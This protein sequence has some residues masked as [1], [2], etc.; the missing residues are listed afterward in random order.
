MKPVL[1]DSAPDLLTRFD[2]PLIPPG[3]QYTA[4]HS[5][6]QHRKALRYAGFASPCKPLQSMNYHS[7]LEQG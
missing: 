5:K 7:K 3:T 6:P 4:T 1:L 2:A